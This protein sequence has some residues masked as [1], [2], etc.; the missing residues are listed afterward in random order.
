MLQIV[1]PVLLND[2]SLRLGDMG[3]ALHLASHRTVSIELNQHTVLRELL[4]NEN[5]L[6]GAPGDEIAAGIE[7]AFVHFGQ[8]HLVLAI[9]IAFA[10]AQ[11]DRYAAD[12]Q[13]VA[14]DTLATARVFDVYH[15]LGGVGE[16]P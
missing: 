12:D 8:L 16:I 1:T 9:E 5:D 11:H 10:A 14:D 3:R 4:L 13:V 15:D 2:R 6:L 7:R